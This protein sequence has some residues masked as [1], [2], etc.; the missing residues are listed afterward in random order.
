[1][2]F[3]VGDK[4]ILNPKIRRCL[5]EY[6]EIGTV[7]NIR[8]T[9][10]TTNFLSIGIWNGTENELILVSKS[11]EKTFFKRLPDDYTGTIEVENG[12]IVK[13]EILDEIEKE[14]LSAVIRPFKDRIENIKKVENYLDSVE[15]ISISVRGNGY[16][17]FPYFK[18]NA[19]YKGM[20]P[21]TVYTLKEL[22]LDE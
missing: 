4:V 14:Y 2:K 21:D 11:N 19:M 5:F 18:K 13:E 8:G 22:G 3:K 6:D 7:I 10:I 16:I 15:F 9:V 17:M 1:M 12:Y 20:K